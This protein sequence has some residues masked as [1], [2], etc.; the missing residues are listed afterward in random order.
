MVYGHFD[1]MIDS[2]V[3]VLLL[4]YAIAIVFQFY[5]GGDKMYE[6]RRRKA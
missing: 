4:F 1:S 3:F 2:F 5:L 6:M